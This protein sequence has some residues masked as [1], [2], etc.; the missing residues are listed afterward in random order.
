[1][2]HSALIPAGELEAIESVSLV[3]SQR[4]SNL[5]NE[6]LTGIYVLLF[7]IRILISEHLLNLCKIVDGETP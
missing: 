7:V 3:G 1:M 5:F 2:K 4:F 6:Y